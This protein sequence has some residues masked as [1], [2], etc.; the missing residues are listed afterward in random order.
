MSVLDQIL[1]VHE[2]YNSVQGESSYAGISCTFVRLAECPLRCRWCD[3]AAAFKKGDDQSISQIID[4][5]SLL[6]AETIELTGGE[7]LAQ[8]VAY[9]LL[10]QLVEHF[11]QRKILIETSGSECIK[12]VDTQVHI[13]MDLKCPGSRMDHK[14]LWSN[15][16]H[17]KPTDE[18]KFVIADKEDFDWAQEVIKKHDL[19]EKTKLLFSPAF[20]LLKPD[21]LVEWMLA[22]QAPARLNLQLHKFIWSPRKQ[23]V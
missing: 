7:P 11:P 17:I 12:D 19:K 1:S 3:T 21:Q 22:A 4:Q 18:I 5:I 16:E 2:I 14:N 20:G 15:L 9:E 13:V 6:P 10:R 8:P 23:G